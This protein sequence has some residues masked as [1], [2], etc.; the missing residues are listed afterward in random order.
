MKVRFRFVIDDIF[1][2]KVVKQSHL[3]T[4]LCEVVSVLSIGAAAPVKPR[5]LWL[6]KRS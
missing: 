6:R 5:C 3:S 4:K 2:I 1:L